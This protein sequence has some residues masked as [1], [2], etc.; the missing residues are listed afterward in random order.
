MNDPKKRPQGR[1]VGT[2]LA[3]S[4][5]SHFKLMQELKYLFGPVNLSAIAKRYDI[6]RGT[7]LKYI[8]EEPGLEEALKAK[9]D[10]N[11]RGYVP[12]KRGTRV[13]RAISKARRESIRPPPPAPEQPHPVRDRILRN[14]TGYLD[15]SFATR[16]IML[17][18]LDDEQDGQYRLA[19]Q[20]KPTAQIKRGQPVSPRTQRPKSE[21]TILRR[22]TLP[23]KQ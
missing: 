11:G 13:T 21:I 16:Q 4:Q 22:R 7:L 23:P 5:H 17:D 2:L 14:A 19:Q 10:A 1:P 3:L 8:K 6:S 9:R 18:E 15:P 20:Q 12:V